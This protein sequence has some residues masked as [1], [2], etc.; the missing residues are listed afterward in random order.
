MEYYSLLEKKINPLI[1]S[2]LIKNFK[3]PKILLGSNLLG[4]TPCAKPSAI[5]SINKQKISLC[6]KKYSIIAP[7]KLH[8][9]ILASIR[10][11]KIISELHFKFKN[12]KGISLSELPFTLR[13]YVSLLFISFHKMMNPFKDYFF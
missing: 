12:K 6:C 13:V 11:K 5:G 7:H 8:L 9:N 4:L 1:K 3:K 10:K 2:R